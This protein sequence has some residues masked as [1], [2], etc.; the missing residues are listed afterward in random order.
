MPW[1]LVVSAALAESYYLESDPVATEAAAGDL[2]QILE[3]AGCKGRV[4]RRYVRGEGWR[5]L[6]RTRLV[7]DADA[8][9]V[10]LQAGEGTGRPVLH[11]VVKD[12]A[13]SR[14]L[15]DDARARIG[16]PSVDD[17]LA[18][19]ETAHH[20]PAGG[21]PPGDVLLFRF[22]RVGP[23][24]RRVRHT[25]AR[26]GDDRYLRVEVLAGEGTSS[27]AGVTD[28]TA[29]LEG[30]GT[31]PDPAHARAQLDRFSPER[32]LPLAW[33]LARGTLDLP[34]RD[35]LTVQAA[36]RVGGHDVVVLGAEGDAT[37]QPLGLEVDAATWRLREVTRGPTGADVTWRFDDW[38]EHASGAFLPA[39]VEVWKG[40]QRAD[41]LEILDLEI[42]PVLPD[43]WF[44]RPP[45]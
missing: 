9:A 16:A 40:A 32:V 14:R 28:G 27:V 21:M 4:A 23:G 15:D 17:L 10:C 41:R 13:R 6:V 19:V 18:R 30:E 12:G 35:H 3:R 39:A 7:D 38:T 2:V 37:T 25:Y 33:D 42:D 5:W 31:M 11:V 45:G 34:E 26:R 36:G 22:V 1:W 29:W 43:A 20:G 24:P 8:I 44:E